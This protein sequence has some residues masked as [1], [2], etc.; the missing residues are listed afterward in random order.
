MRWL[1][2]FVLVLTP[3]RARAQ[4]GEV[5]PKE[6]K[7]IAQFKGGP[8][9]GGKRDFPLLS[10]PDSG[11]PKGGIVFRNAAEL[12]GKMLGDEKKGKDESEQKKA[13]EW[14]AKVLKVERI[15]WDKQTLLVIYGGYF[16]AD[17]NEVH[18]VSMTSNGKVLTVTYDVPLLDKMTGSHAPLALVLIEKFDGD[19]KFVAEGRAKEVPPA[20]TAWKVIAAISAGPP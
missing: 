6:W 10:G 2:L 11:A 4:E 8:V 15:D 12:A 7:V 1:A 14:A 17:G 19:V 20:P 16:R 5:A 18:L 3:A 13:A 9:I